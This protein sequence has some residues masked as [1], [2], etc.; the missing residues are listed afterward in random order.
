MLA[1]APVVA[2]DAVA[3]DNMLERHRQARSVAA[4]ADIEQARIDG[5]VSRVDDVGF[6]TTVSVGQLQSLGVGDHDLVA[7][8]V[9]GRDLRARLVLQDDYLKIVGDREGRGGIDVDV[10]VVTGSFDAAALVTV[11]GLG[12]ALADWLQ[13]RSGDPVSMA[14]AEGGGRGGR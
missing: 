12:G 7:I 14:P 8:A 13:V 2:A 9:A 6:G 11:V 4:R 3:G 5:R 10:V 1:M